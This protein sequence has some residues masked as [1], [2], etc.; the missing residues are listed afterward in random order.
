MD[1]GARIVIG[2]GYRKDLLNLCNQ[3]SHIMHLTVRL[4]IRNLCERSINIVSFS[5]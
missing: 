2:L 1:V 3:S 4:I 5:D